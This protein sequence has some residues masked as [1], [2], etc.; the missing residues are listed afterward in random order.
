MKKQSE[1]FGLFQL[2]AMEGENHNVGGARHSFIA[3]INVPLIQL[4]PD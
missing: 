4:I 3:H 1:T 2:A